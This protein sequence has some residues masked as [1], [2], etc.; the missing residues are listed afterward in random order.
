MDEFHYYGDRD[1]GIAWELPLLLLPKSQ[2]LLMSATLGNTAAKERG[3]KAILKEMYDIFVRMNARYLSIL[4]TA[5]HL[6][7]R[8]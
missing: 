3:F 1:R 5:R 7:A 8:L 4:H 2:F 6:Y